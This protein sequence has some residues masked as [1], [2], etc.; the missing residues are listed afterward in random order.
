MLNDGVPPAAERTIARGGEQ[1]DGNTFKLEP[2][3]FM[4]I[5][6]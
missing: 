5:R 2:Y 6:D 4:I 1:T 3:G